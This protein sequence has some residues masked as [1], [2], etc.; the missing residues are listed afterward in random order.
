MRERAAAG[1]LPG[2]THAEAVEQER[3]ERELLREAPVHR[4]ASFRHRAAPGEDRLELRMRREVRWCRRERL[5][6]GRELLARHRGVRRRLIL[7]AGDLL[8]GVERI[9]AVMRWR[10]LRLRP[11]ERFLQL[12]LELL[13]PLFRF[14]RI[15]V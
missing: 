6:D 5:A 12:G 2:E 14:F 9:A 3:S 7:E 11:V 15:D 8:V 10:F 13:E 1:V 4:L